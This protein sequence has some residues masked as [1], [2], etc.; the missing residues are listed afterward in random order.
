MKRINEMTKVRF[1]VKDNN[2]NYLF[3]GEKQCSPT[4]EDAYMY[5]MNKSGGV[6]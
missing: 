6:K 1:A 2:S 5:I 4:V 3:K